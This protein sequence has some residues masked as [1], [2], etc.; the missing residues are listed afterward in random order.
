VADKLKLEIRTAQG[1]T[2]TPAPG[3]TGPLANPRFLEALFAPDAVERKRNTEAVEISPN[4]MVSGRIVQY[5]PVRAR[6]FEEVKDQVRERVVATRAAEL[7]RKE[8][9][10]KLAAWK[11]NPAAAELPAAMPLSR[12]D[13]GKQPRPLIEAAL[14]TDPAK[15]PALVG[16]DLG[17]DGY[18]VVRVNKL[19]PRDTVAPQQAQQELQQYNRA[20][21]TAEAMAYYDALK[22][23]FKTQINVPRPASGATQ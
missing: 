19:L 2:R 16:V 11:A 22:S 7:A 15:L 14:R 8:G 12:Q 23:R 17:P 9:E 3:A 21:G 1:V 4:Q 5:A 6:P 10:A 18:A 20:W 13:Q